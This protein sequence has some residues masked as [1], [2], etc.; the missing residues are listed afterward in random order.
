MSSVVATGVV[1]ASS[2]RNS[3]TR[4]LSEIRS[5]GDRPAGRRT[6]IPGS[7]ITGPGNRLARAHLWCP[8]D[9]DLHF[10]VARANRRRARSRQPTWL[11]F[12]CGLNWG[13]WRRGTVR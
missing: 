8:T 13:S 6:R 2:P 4:R 11:G 7:A 5:A 9:L 10:R 12:R 3:Q 1:V